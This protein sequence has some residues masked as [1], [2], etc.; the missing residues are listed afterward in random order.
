MDLIYKKSTSPS[1]PI[2]HY[3]TNCK[4]HFNYVHK[5]CVIRKNVWNKK[6]IKIKTKML[7]FEATIT[8]ILFHYN[9]KKNQ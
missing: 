7:Y 1:Y 8:V 2:A 4:S 6:E 5:I 3:L 9:E